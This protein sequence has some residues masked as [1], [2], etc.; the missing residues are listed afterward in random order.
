MYRDIGIPDRHPQVACVCVS[1]DFVGTSVDL[2][3]TNTDQ[4]MAPY[5]GTR[6][7]VVVQKEMLLSVQEAV[8][9]RLPAVIPT[10]CPYRA[11]IQQL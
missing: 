1:C 4:E 9:F 7:G 11:I 10:T 2:L 6:F 3:E 8:P 5:G